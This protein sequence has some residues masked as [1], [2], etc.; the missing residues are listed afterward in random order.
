MRGGI[1]LNLWSDVYSWREA[2]CLLRST[3]TLRTNWYYANSHLP[4]NLREKALWPPPD[5][6]LSRLV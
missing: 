2:W 4:C 5:A 3:S 1:T 6:V